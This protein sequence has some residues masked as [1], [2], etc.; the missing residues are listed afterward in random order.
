[1]GYA[2]AG[3]AR[4]AGAG[5]AAVHLPRVPDEGAVLRAVC[6][7]VQPAGRLCRP[8]VVRARHVLRL[9]RLRGRTPGQDRHRAAALRASLR[10]VGVADDPLA[11]AHAGAGHPDRHARCR[12]PRPHRRCD[13]HPP[14]GHLLRDGHAGAGADGVLPVRAGAVHGR[15]GRHPGHPPAT[16]VRPAAADQR[17]RLLLRGAGDIRGRLPDHLPHHPFALRPGAQGHPRERGAGDL[18][19]LRR[20]PL[21]ADGVRALGRACRPCRRH[22]GHRVPARLA[23]R[24]HVADVGRGGADDACGRPRHGVRPDRR[25]RHHHHDAELSRR[26]SASGC[27]SSRARSSSSRCCCSGAASWASSSPSPAAG[28]A[29]ASRQDELAVEGSVRPAE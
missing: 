23:H 24:C 9:C 2:G 16:A 14:A 22:Q 1:M 10:G 19:G 25:R 26:L 11:A 28:R 13:R 12:P 7:R 5:G 6:V 17:L 29:K 27:W 8:A 21:Q 18:A 3:G 4:G 20:G 15:R